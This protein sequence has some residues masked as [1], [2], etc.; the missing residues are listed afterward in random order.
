MFILTSR[1]E[2]DAT[3][4]P[5]TRIE[6]GQHREKEKLAHIPRNQCRW[7]VFSFDVMAHSFTDPHPQ[8]GRGGLVGE[9]VL[10]PVA[11]YPPTSMRH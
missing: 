11:G 10:D 6:A 5:S 2:F 1:I 7:G 9:Q 8:S 4:L 3:K